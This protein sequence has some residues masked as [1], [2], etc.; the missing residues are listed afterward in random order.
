MRCRKCPPEIRELLAKLRKHHDEQRAKMKFGSQKAFFARIWDRLHYK[1]PNVTPKRK[2]K[3]KEQ[4]QKL[5]PN[6]QAAIQQQQQQQASF[7]TAMAMQ[8][9]G[10]DMINKRQ[11]LS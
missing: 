8:Q 4:Q 1:D 5:P 3:G 9:F 7:D 10:V 6:L 11:K 2:F